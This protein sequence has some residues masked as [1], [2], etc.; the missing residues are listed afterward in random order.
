MQP[1]LRTE[2]IAID[3]GARVDTVHMWIVGD[4]LPAHKVS[5][6]SKLPTCEMVPCG[7]RADGHPSTGGVRP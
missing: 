1:P 6:I 7:P 4:G 2:R 3:F 5:R